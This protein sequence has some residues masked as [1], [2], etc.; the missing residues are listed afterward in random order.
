MP[1]RSGRSKAAPPCQ[2]PAVPAPTPP[3][4][5]SSLPSRQEPGLLLPLGSR[6]PR[7]TDRPAG[8]WRPPA[9]APPARTS[10]RRRRRRRW[11]G[12]GAGAAASA[13]SSA[14]PSG[15]KRGPG[16]SAPPWLC[17]KRLAPGAALLFAGNWAS[18][19][20]SFPGCLQTLGPPSPV[21]GQR[22]G[23]RS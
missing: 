10:S 16:G 5:P 21:Q 18:P 14:R 12:R 6:S 15:T 2:R 22:C 19:P 9:P 17:G 23:L 3:G 8:Q 1:E 7:A 4:G 13:P 11:E 20:A